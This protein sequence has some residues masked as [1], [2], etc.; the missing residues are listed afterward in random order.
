[1]PTTTSY[2]P[3]SY[4][5]PV[6][7]LQI[8]SLELRARAVVEGFFAGLH[9]S[10]FHGFSVEFTEYRQYVPGDDPRRLD[11]RLYARSDRYFVKQY[12]DET[13][14]RCHVVVDNSRSMAFGTLPHT[15]AEYAKTLAATLAYFLHTQR[16]AIGL[17]LVDEEIDAFIPARHRAGQFRRIVHALEH[18]PAGR[19]TRIADALE[20]VAQRVHKRGLLVLISDFLT[21]LDALA[22]RFM[23]LQARGHD[24]VAFQVLDPAELSFDFDEPT[25]FR[26]MET[27]REVF[28]EPA[29]A[30]APYRQRMQRHLEELAAIA[31]ARGVA[32]YRVSTDTPLESPLREFLSS[33]QR[34]GGRGRRIAPTGI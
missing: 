13:N 30:G 20:Q 28:V 32:L 9:R 5:D 31:V 8:A 16:D 12:E 33:R 3:P 18:P 7:L 23:Y 19:A 34:A 2:P 17:V 22:T 6:A 1:M 24:V 26:D 10:P 14:L 21:P 15:K 4:I 29:A 27:G 25:L 11:W